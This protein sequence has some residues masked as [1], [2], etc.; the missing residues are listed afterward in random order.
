M[1]SFEREMALT[2]RISTKLIGNTLFIASTLGI[3][4]EYWSSKRSSRT[5]EG[6]CSLR[7]CRRRLSIVECRDTG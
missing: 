3:S 1:I 2:T 5:L 6:C 4:A 7:S